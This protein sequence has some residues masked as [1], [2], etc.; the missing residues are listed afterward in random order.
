[1]RPV[2]PRKLPF[3]WVDECPSLL[4]SGSVDTLVELALEVDARMRADFG[5][6]LGLIWID[7]VAVAGG[8]SDANDSVE[9]TALMTALRAIG[10]RTGS[11]VIGVDHFGKMIETGTRGSSA[12]EDHADTVLAML[13]ERAVDGSMSNLRMC[14]RKVR[15]ARS[16]QVIPFKLDVV[17]IGQ[18][19]H[20]EPI[21]TCVVAWDLDRRTGSQTKPAKTLPKSLVTFRK[22]LDVALLEHGQ[23]LRPYGVKGSE[24][25]AVPVLR[26][27]EEFV[28]S[29]A[30]GGDTEDKKAEA[31]ATAFRRALKAVQDHQLA[32]AREIAGTEFLWSNASHA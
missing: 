26:V 21:T 24:V 6:P 7:T 32:T 30:T 13:G 23:K 25:L 20:L 22:A 27:R 2:D 9:N 16:G 14:V 31:K 18:N 19:R 12:K 15:G 1:M 28:R 4:A 29:Y 10:T 3:A 5:L 17:E 11:F 8:V